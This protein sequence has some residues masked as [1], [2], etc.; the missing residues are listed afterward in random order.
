MVSISIDGDR[1]HFDVQGVDKLWAFKSHLDMPL[2][3][4][5]AV[6]IDP[7][8]AKGWWHGLRLPGTNLPGVIVAGTFHQA[9]GW[10]FF[11][12]HDPERTIVV[13][14]EH[15]HYKHLVIEVADPQGEVARLQ[16]AIGR[17]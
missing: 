2:E 6:R 8:E 11:D 12:V 3:H 1:V 17:G 16:A 9:E 14:L 10:V 13:D 5:R 4:I 15:E 7:D